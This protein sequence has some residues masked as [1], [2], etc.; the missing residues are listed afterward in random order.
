MCLSLFSFLFQTALHGVGLLPESSQAKEW[1]CSPKTLPAYH[2]KPLVI[3]AEP[4]TG[5]NLLFDMM[6]TFVRKAAQDLEI[7]P[8]SELFTK[9]TNHNSSVL[10][11]AVRKAHESV[12]LSCNLLGNRTEDTTERKRILSE[13]SKLEGKH[14][15]NE[16]VEMVA[17]QV[18]RFGLDQ[19]VNVTRSRYINPKSY[20]G[21][22]RNV[23]SQV[24]H[25][26]FAF[27]FAPIS[28]HLHRHQ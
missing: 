2:H 1:S 25:P 17:V 28:N 6:K 26:Y 4:R 10:A 13:I 27:I 19:L 5:S 18:K 9:D 11:K 21:F 24:K 16:T 23:P 15:Y 20:F 7:M 8:L 22:L 12:S 14:K 3:F